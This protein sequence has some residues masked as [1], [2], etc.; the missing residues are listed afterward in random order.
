MLTK[1]VLRLL[2]AEGAL[3]G[4]VV[5]DAAIKGDGC[6]RAA[7]PVVVTVAQTGCP[8]VLSL[9]WCDVNVETRIAAP[10]PWV[11]TGQV[12][13]LFDRDAPLIVVGPMPASLPP[14]VVGAVTVAVPAG[15][16]GAAP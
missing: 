11:T 3:L 1:I 16:L 7:G 14:I 15:G 9:H 2:D 6:L 13:T 5:H 8:A 12:V 10:V 4:A